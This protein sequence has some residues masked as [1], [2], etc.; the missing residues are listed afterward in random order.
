L[1]PK[2]RSPSNRKKDSPGSVLD[3]EE[4]LDSVLAR[5]EHNYGANHPEVSVCLY[6]KLLASPS[7][8][9]ASHSELLASPSELL[10]SPSELLASPSEL[11]AS[12]SELLASP[13]ELSASPSES[14]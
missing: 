6:I 13:S 7:E 5:M 4:K 14:S 12:P 9:L 1:S 11:L 2:S 8:L 3:Q 10:A